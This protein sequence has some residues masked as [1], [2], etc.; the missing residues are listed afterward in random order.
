M[1][2]GVIGIIVAIAIPA[3]LSLTGQ[4]PPMG[5]PPH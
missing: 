3:Y 5:V 1:I 4:L 2:L